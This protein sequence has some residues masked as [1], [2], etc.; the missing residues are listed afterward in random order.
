MNEHEAFKGQRHGGRGVLQRLRK[1]RLRGRSAA[2]E[3]PPG[4][5]NCRCSRENK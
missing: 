4:G 2:M 1:N 3:G 5:K